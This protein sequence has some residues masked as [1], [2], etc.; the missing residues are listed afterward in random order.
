MNFYIIFILISFFYLES[1]QTPKLHLPVFVW[2]NKEFYKGI[3]QRISTPYSQESILKYISIISQ[4]TNEQ[5]IEDLDIHNYISIPENTNLDVVIF[6][7]LPE[8][9]SDELLPLT[10]ACEGKNLLSYIAEEI[11]T[12]SK[13]SLLFSQMHQENP[14]SFQQE[15]DKLL[16]PGE[17][18]F[19]KYL[20][21]IDTFVPQDNQFTIEKKITNEKLS[22]VLE[23]F[24]TN[25]NSNTKFI[26]VDIARLPQQEQPLCRGTNLI[27]SFLKFLNQPENQQISYIQVF[28]ANKPSLINENIKFTFDQNE[29]SENPSLLSFDDSFSQF[30]IQN[31]VNDAWNNL[32]A[33]IFLMTA[34]FV[35][36]FYILIADLNK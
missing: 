8:M 5:K 29:N 34:L 31:Q 1:F 15:L 9:R 11:M 32:L 22:S 25:S 18:L 33:I 3:N 36:A 4:K 24:I 13:S 28:T 27:D 17:A 6:F 16:I 2:S 19:L 23:E 7:I 30:K 21:Q 12:K 10:Q 20:P 26:L 14:D 35:V